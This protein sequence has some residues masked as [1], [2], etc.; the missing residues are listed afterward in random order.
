M[1]NVE[2]GAGCAILGLLFP[3]LLVGIV[4]IAV[5]GVIAGIFGVLISVFWF[6]AKW[7]LAPLAILAFIFYLLGRRK[8]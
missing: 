4:I 3:L 5:I 7:L 6:L 8:N 2:S 1:S